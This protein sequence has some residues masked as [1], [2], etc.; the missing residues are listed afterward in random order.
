MVLRILRYVSDLH[1]ELRSNIDH[2]KLK[3]LW[4]QDSSEN[5]YYLALV[6]DIGNPYHET[7]ELFLDLVSPKY[8]KIFY[9]PGNHEYYNYEVIPCRPKNDFDLELEKLCHKYDNVILMN[10]SV[11]D[12]DGIK[13][14]GS[15]LW[16]NIPET[17]SDIITKINDYYLIKKIDHASLVP[18]DIDDTNQWNKQSIDFIESEIKD[19]S[20]PC[21]VLTHHAPLFSDPTTERYTANPSYLDGDNNYA[22][23]N[24]LSYLMKNPI[25]AWIYGHTHYTS[26][27]EYNG[28]IVT[29]NQ[30]GYR[31]EDTHFNPYAYLDLDEIFMNW[32]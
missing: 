4:N 15:T 21:I 22:F 31:H 25:C 32:L 27:F 11:Y 28:I 1:L 20:D 19:A 8:R 17:H 10:N 30:L 14:I 24:D 7:L 6:G 29:T 2:P 18:I 16:S 13:I 26:R 12:L 5:E 9:V 23:H 3:P